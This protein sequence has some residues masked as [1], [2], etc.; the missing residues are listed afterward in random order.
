MRRFLNLYWAELVYRATL[1]RRYALGTAADIATF[2]LLFMGI[3]WSLRS[4]MGELPPPPG[5]ASDCRL[6]GHWLCGLL[7]R[8]Y[9]A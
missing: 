7:L 6:A 2:Y 1:L 3:H 4:L 5:A 8:R 9:G